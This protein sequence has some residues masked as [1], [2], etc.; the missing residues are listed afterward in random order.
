MTTDPLLELEGITKRFGEVVANDDI[1]FSVDRGE[2][3][4]LSARTERAKVR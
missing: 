3:H 4:A 2:V 1:S